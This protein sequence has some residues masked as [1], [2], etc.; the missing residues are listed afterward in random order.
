MGWQ[1]APVLEEAE[2]LP[3][4]EPSLAKIDPAVQAARDHIAQG[5]VEREMALEPENEALKQEHQL[6]FGGKP[7]EK[8]ASWQE[9]PPVEEPQPELQPSGGTADEH[10]AARMKEKKPER[11]AQLITNVARWNPLAG[12]AMAGIEATTEKLYGEGVFQLW[13]TESLPARLVSATQKGVFKQELGSLVREV[14]DNVK[15]FD[16][17]EI[18]EAAKANPGAFAFELFKSVATDPWLVVAPVGLGGRVAGA[19][20]KAGRVAAV[21]GR[22]VETG[23]VGAGMSAL[24]GV[25]QQLDEEGYI[26]PRVVGRD[27][28]IGAFLG[29]IIGTAVHLGSDLTKVP[30]RSIYEDL[31]KRLV[32]GKGSPTDA[33]QAALEAAGVPAGK[34]RAIREAADLA[35]KQPAVAEKAAAVERVRL[36]QITP[37]EERRV[38]LG[39]K[40]L[41]P[42]EAER[43]DELQRVEATRKGAFERD[44]VV[45]EREAAQERVRKGEIE[46][47]EKLHGLLNKDTLTPSEVVEAQALRNRIDVE[48]TSRAEAARQ[49][50]AVS[51]SEL[52]GWFSGRTGITDPK[53]MLASVESAARSRVLSS[54]PM[55][56]KGIVDPAFAKYLAMV[57]VAGAAGGYLDDDELR[58]A[59]IGSGLVLAALAG[60]AGLRA[61]DRSLSK[62][63]FG[64]RDTRFRIDDMRRKWHGDIQ[65]PGRHLEIETSLLRKALPT[66]RRK[67]LGYFIEAEAGD[68]L[69]A[70]DLALGPKTEAERLYV[71]Y[72]RALSAKLGKAAT[73]TTDL[74]GKPLLQNLVQE[75]GY[76]THLYGAGKGER[77]RSFFSNMSPKFRFAL[78]RAY[79]KLRAAEAAGLTPLTT[80]GAETLRIYGKSLI[81]SIANVNFLKSLREGTTPEGQKLLMTSAKAPDGYVT[82]NHP[83]LQGWKV[84]PDI[85]PTLKFM[86]S[87]DEPNAISQ[88]MLAASVL[89]KASLFSFSLFHDMSLVQALLGASRLMRTG[90]KS[91][92]R[93]GE[94]HRQLFKDPR[95]GDLVDTALGSGGVIIDHHGGIEN[96]GAL[97]DMLLSVGNFADRYTAGIAGKPIHFAN[98]V[99]DKL[100]AFLWGYLHPVIKISTFMAEY[101]RGLKAQAL[102][103]ERGGVPLPPEKVARQVGN[104]VNDIFGGQNW[105]D[106]AEGV[107]NRYG[108]EIALA[109]FSPAGRRAMQIA[110]LAPDWTFATFRSGVKALP[111]ITEPEIAAMH[112]SYILSSALMYLTVGDA[113]NY[114]FS[115]HHVWENKDPTYIDLGDGRKMQLNKHFME[116][117]H[118]LQHPGQTLR[119]KLGFLPKVAI[120]ATDNTKTTEQ[121]AKDIARMAV[122]ISGS[123]LVQGE[124]GEEAIAGFV[125]TP[126]YGTP[127]AEQAREKERKR[128]LKELEAIN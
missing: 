36:G 7:L 99:N 108:R 19:L 85:E 1:D 93:L 31:R 25:G 123:A 60:G 101:E 26:D 57:T 84:H 50:N 100:N 89:A 102:V 11:G 94:A 16:V 33:L 18:W 58:G 76:I 2:E 29:A 92:A 54:L 113:L 38:L 45:Q 21:A 37:E 55:S 12:F 127:T 128:L 120:I 95:Y 121:K 116:L 53:E 88:A 83:Q 111:G 66:A 51:P 8:P 112:R 4:G 28:G 22:A 79:P 80:D 78:S 59:A 81:R 86:F 71:D 43:L 87:L 15:S 125:G 96:A 13:T 63:S 98:A 82:I 49:F 44:E 110:L 34:A 65:I 27:L 74:N 52:R 62:M 40:A 107:K 3:T 117:A 104:A 47:E 5:I 67:E 72:F 109:L 39:K 90:P 124:S 61:L 9:A 77:A 64:P 73:E 24:I 68:P 41:S 32:T 17:G 70:K 91:W 115:G 35:V 56:Q 69:T 48:A 10:I 23:A 103:A 97:H 119:N 126:I 30:S 42:R 105:L 122:P 106:I 114:H 20:G 118:W 6:R 14:G 46:N 75:G